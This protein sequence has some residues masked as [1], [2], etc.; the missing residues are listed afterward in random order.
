MTIED[1]QAIMQK[2]NQSLLEAGHGEIHKTPKEK[3][4]YVWQDQE[5]K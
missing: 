1:A 2:N 3:G 4:G 5:K